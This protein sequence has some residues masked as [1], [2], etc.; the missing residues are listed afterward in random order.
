[1]S[2]ADVISFVEPGAGIL[3]TYIRLTLGLVMNIYPMRGADS[4]FWLAN[5]H[6]I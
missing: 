2:G 5:N 6:E 4:R 1:M 3:C